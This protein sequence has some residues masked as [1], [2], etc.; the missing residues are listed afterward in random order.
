M[1]SYMYLNAYYAIV[2]ISFAM[3]YIGEK[4]RTTFHVCLRIDDLFGVPAVR[5]F[6]NGR[7]GKGRMT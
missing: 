3:M 4:M 5:E 6:R 1:S 7:E 2:F